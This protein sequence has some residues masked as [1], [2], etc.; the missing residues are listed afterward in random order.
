MISEEEIKNA[1]T[2]TLRYMLASGITGE[3]YN[4]TL[5]EYLARPDRKGHIKKRRKINEN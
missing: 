2:K 3:E 4:L 1:D 5:T